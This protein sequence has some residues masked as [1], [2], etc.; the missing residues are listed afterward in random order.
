V[1][2]KPPFASNAKEDLKLIGAARRTAL[3]E[4]SEPVRLL[5][6]A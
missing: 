1:L 3:N 6:I 5:E 2:K 4:P